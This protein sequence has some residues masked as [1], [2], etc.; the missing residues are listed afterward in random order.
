METEKTLRVLMSSHRT[1]AFCPFCETETLF[2]PTDVAAALIHESP[3]LIY[4][5]IENSEV[6]FHETEENKVLVCVAS[7]FSENEK[8]D[9]V[10]RK[11]TE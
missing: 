11:E 2:V 3:R 6:H 4:R 7:L 9:L 5:R 1:K 10:L 8:Q